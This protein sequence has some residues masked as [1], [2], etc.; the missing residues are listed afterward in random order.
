[1]ALPV[2]P[3]HSRD[4][5]VDPPDRIARRTS[6]KSRG[7]FAGWPD[8]C[9][10]GTARATVALVRPE[11]AAYAGR[12]FNLSFDKRLNALFDRWL[13]G[14]VSLGFIPMGAAEENAEGGKQGGIGSFVCRSIRGSDQPSNHSSATAVD[15]LTRSN[16]MLV[17]RDREP[18][19]FRSTIPPVL[20]DLAA[21]GDIYWGGWYRDDT[22]WY[23][24]PMHFEYMARPEDVQS[25]LDR[26]EARLRALKGSTPNGVED[27]DAEA[28]RALQ[29]ALNNAVDARLVVDGVYGPA[30][31]RAVTDLPAKVQLITQDAI[32]DAATAEAKITEA[33][34]LA[35]RIGAL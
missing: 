22:R 4:E 10:P 23:S 30:T 14:A 18:V 7:W 17:S 6:A 13:N 34:R 20:V 5:Y 32:G 27:V 1:M 3:R 12:T 26:L 31:A 24:D 16:P 21:A 29:V 19:P 33:K 8:N 15:I 28:V 11:T 35:A 25:S 2:L 9:P